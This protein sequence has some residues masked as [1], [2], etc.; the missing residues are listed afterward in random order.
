MCT[1][2]SEALRTG[3]THQH[4][5]HAIQL[6]SERLVYRCA[7]TLLRWCSRFWHWVRVACT[8][9]KWAHRRKV[10]QRHPAHAQECRELSL[11]GVVIQRR[12]WCGLAPR[13]LFV[14][15]FP[16]VEANRRPRRNGHARDKEEGDSRLAAGLE[17]HSEKRGLWNRRVRGVVLSAGCAVTTVRFEQKF[18]YV[19]LYKRFVG[20]DP[21]SPPRVAN[22]DPS[23][24]DLYRVVI[25]PA[26]LP[27]KLVVRLVRLCGATQN[28]AST[29]LVGSG[30]GSN[31]GCAHVILPAAYY[32]NRSLGERVPRRELDTHAIC[33][34]AE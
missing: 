30:G 31:T 12:W 7:W 17:V 21:F 34:P 11:I 10:V 15:P 4:N 28:G 2:K 5:L 6:A 20:C 29:T 1:E 27:D 13:A 9:S 3:T 32:Q 24:V 18:V 19:V 8:G 23:L 26:P 16:I 25:D 22:E 14:V 33:F